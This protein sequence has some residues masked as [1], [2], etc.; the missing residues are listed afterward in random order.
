MVTRRTL[1]ASKQALTLEPVPE[2]LIEGED[3][4]VESLRSSEPRFPLRPLFREHVCRG[5]VRA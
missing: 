3:G 2:V 4:R 1:R 5:K